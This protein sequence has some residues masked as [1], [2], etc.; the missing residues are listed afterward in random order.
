M[1]FIFAVA[2]VLFLDRIAPAYVTRIWPKGFSMTGAELYRRYG[3]IKFPRT[4]IGLTACLPFLAPIF[5][6]IS[7]TIC[8]LISIPLMILFIVF[9]GIDIFKTRKG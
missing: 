1:I 9:A 6:P 8:L 3:L 4:I 2:V 5:F 7:N